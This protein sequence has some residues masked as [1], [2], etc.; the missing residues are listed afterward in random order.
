MHPSG[1]FCLMASH[2]SIDFL[3][4]AE[5]YQKSHF[6]LEMTYIIHMIWYQINIW[7]SSYKQKGTNVLLLLNRV[8]YLLF[9]WVFS[10]AVKMSIYTIYTAFSG[11]IKDKIHKYIYCIICRENTEYMYT[12]QVANVPLTHWS[13]LHW[14]YI[15][16]IK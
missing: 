10:V 3:W 16:E 11:K 8:Y 9:F 7:K 12:F 13:R 1:C 14:V 6:Q 5:H 15:E 2:I 4:H